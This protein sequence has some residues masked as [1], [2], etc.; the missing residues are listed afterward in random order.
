M[1]FEEWW[2]KVIFVDDNKSQ[3]T[4]RDVVLSVVN[5]DGGAHI[6]PQLDEAYA[7]LSRSNALKWRLETESGPIELIGPESAAIRQIANELQR[8]LA[9]SMPNLR[10]DI[11]TGAALFLDVGLAVDQSTPRHPE[12]P[13][14]GRNAPCPCGSGKKYKR[15]Y[16]RA[17][18]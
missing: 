5:Q 11:P 12:V 18:R 15:C 7:H 1:S 13:K 17:V 16:L 9:P 14:V 8:S 2:K 10:P 4:R 6:D 3:F